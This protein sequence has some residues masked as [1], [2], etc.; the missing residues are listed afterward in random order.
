M[1]PML[2]RIGAAALFLLCA[3]VSQAASLRVA[4]TN[5]ELIAPDSAAVLNLHNDAKQPIN[6]Q[7]RV[8][9]WSQVD[10]VERLEPTSDV[11]AS[12]PST[13]LGPDADYVVRVV[14]LS[15]IPVRSEESYRVLVDELPDQ[16]RRKAGTVT[17]V[18]R[19]S[20]PVFF[21]N[22]DAKTPDVSFS[23]SRARGGLVLTARNNGESRLRLSNINLTQGG[24]KLGSRSGLVGYVLGG[25]IM[26][27]PIGSRRSLSGSSVTLK[28]QSDFGP[29]NAPV[30]IKGQ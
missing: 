17:L 29:F 7:L 14:R 27:W 5:L 20:V 19:Y 30:A 23:L 26:Q 9:K 18:L 1:P 22:P 28:A 8:F 12:P 3:T 21:R 16:S 2:S 25:A 10:G 13:Q 11:V 24:K 15:K 4:P 6:V